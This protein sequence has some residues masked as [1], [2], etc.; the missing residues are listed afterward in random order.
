MLLV[1]EIEMSMANTTSKRYFCE[2]C[3]QQL[4]KTS[5]FKHKRLY[6]DRKSETWKKERVHYTDSSEDFNEFQV[7]ESC[8]GCDSSNHETFGEFFSPLKTSFLSLLIMH[9]SM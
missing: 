9:L 2:H 4:S 1:L 6:Y 3:E 7:A 8:Q 5:Y